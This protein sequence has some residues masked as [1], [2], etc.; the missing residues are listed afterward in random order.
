MA[1]YIVMPK[2]GFDMREAQLVRW[3]KEV[4][5]QV[6]K[7][8]IV[9]EIESDKATLELEAQAGGVLLKKLANDGDVVP[10]GGNM[11]IVGQQGEDVS[12]MDGAGQARPAAEAKPA[13][14]E[15]PAPQ[16]APA[17][18][19]AAAA[20]P[21][22]EAPAKQEAAAAPPA[23]RPEAEAKPAPDGKAPA[24]SEE[25]PGGVK[26]TPVARRI[27]REH[28][29]DL[30]QVAASGP[31]GRVRKADVESFLERR[32]AAPAPAVAPAVAPAAVPVGPDTAEVELT[33]LRKA[34]GRRMAESKTTAPHFYVTT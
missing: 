22:K 9:A 34:I 2:L 30:K 27:A 25:Y 19:E 7:G 26:A 12:G 16:E 31:G 18:E 15:A 28:E 11:A 4:G 17:E 21:E 24:V 32:E 23:A 3:L 10:V 33:R 14:K 29:V 5:D 13:G 6:N 1:E 8:D 20:P